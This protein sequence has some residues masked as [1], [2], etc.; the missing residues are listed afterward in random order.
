M[1]NTP[2][3]NTAIYTSTGKTLRQSVTLKTVRVLK[4]G[5]SWNAQSTIETSQ[6]GQKQHK[7]DE[8]SIR[9]IMP[10]S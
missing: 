5:T 3:P 9:V 1:I 4:V 10:S 2:T 7:N 6:E 8:N